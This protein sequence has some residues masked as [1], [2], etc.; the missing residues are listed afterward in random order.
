VLLHG[1]AGL[2]GGTQ[3]EIVGMIAAQTGAPASAAAVA[4]A[5]VVVVLVVVVVLLVGLAP[6]AAADDDGDGAL[7][8]TGAP[9]SQTA[10]YSHAWNYYGLSWYCC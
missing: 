4:A 2:L 6:A 9:S 7:G 10:H 3:G 8:K 1:S 5:L